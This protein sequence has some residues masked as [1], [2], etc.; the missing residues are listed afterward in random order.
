MYGKLLAL[1]LTLTLTAGCAGHR[2][3]EPTPTVAID[4]HSRIVGIW[5][6]WP[7]RNGIANVAEYRADGT[8]HLH[9]FN[10]DRDTGGEVEV[11]AYR[12]AD[13]GRSIH[14]KSPYREFDLKVLQFAD[15]EMRLAMTVADIELKF[16]YQKVDEARPLCGF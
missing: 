10:C 2:K 12:V 16:Q 5:A 4:D 11:S 14:V 15:D 3:A 1:S 8:V 6:M 7:L 9:P 13:D